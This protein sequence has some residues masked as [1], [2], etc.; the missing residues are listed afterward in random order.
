MNFATQTRNQAKQYA[1]IGGILLFLS[2]LWISYPML[3][4]T[5]TS[6]YYNG[7]KS[8]GAV[9]SM[10]SWDSVYE[11]LAPGGAIDGENGDSA[12]S[13]L[14]MPTGDEGL[15]FQYNGVGASSASASA[16]AAASSGG[17]G[18]SAPRSSKSASADY[19][20]GG[21]AAALQAKLQAMS[22]GL[23][24][25]GGGSSSGSAGA[26]K[27][28]TASASQ[29]S[30]FSPGGTVGSGSMGGPA[31]SGTGNRSLSSLEKTVQ[32]SAAAAQSGNVAS[33]AAA[34]G[35]AFGDSSPKLK[36]SMDGVEVVKSGISRLPDLGADRL[37]TN[38]DTTGNVRTITYPTV[39]EATEESTSEEDTK[40]Q[41]MKMLLQIGLTVAMGALFGSMGVTVASIIFSNLSS[42]LKF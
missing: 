34:A 25:G 21:L 13:R 17:R 8:K 19:S 5:A 28:V 42:S 24:G 2:G 36:V 30:A 11:G 6:D 29:K 26:S 20:A 33:M 12:S 7:G 41:M 1:V 16:G 18:V 23:S 15:M 37:N 14:Y 38:H 4:N 27:G 3:T 9:A 32:L 10:K 31:G 22:S 39:P 40:T 35:A